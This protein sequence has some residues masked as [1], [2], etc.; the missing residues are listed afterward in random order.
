MVGPFPFLYLFQYEIFHKKDSIVNCW[1]HGISEIPLKLLS[2][3]KLMDQQTLIESY[4]EENKET[5]DPDKS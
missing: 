5:Y 1:N 2:H 4:Q 3:T